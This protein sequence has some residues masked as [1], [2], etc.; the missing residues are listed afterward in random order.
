[1]KIYTIALMVLCINIGFN[2]VALTGI[3]PDAH[4]TGDSNLITHAKNLIPG[5]GQDASFRDATDSST[6][7]DYSFGLNL[8]GLIGDFLFPYSILTSFFGLDEVVAGII[9]APIGLLYFM[10]VIQ[11]L[12]NQVDL[13]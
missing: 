4:N 6:A 13:I 2:L 3:F 11:I 9:C 5:I 12:R 7:S 8:F 10:S 1:M